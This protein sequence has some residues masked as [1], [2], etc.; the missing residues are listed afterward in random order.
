MLGRCG[1]LSPELRLQ[2]VLVVNNDIYDLVVQ[3]LN[4]FL[5]KARAQLN[6]PEDLT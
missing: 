3:H 5:D 1:K 6:L 2:K 4:D